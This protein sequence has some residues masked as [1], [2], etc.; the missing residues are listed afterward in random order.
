M[1]WIS[2]VDHAIGT[3]DGRHAGAQKDRNDQAATF[4]SLVWAVAY[5]FRLTEE[6]HSL[7]PDV[8]RPYTFG[9]PTH[10]LGGAT[11]I[12]VRLHRIVATNEPVTTS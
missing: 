6:V 7:A 2:E 11:T 1:C 4:L 10:R 12:T 3:H 9:I 5:C 8:C